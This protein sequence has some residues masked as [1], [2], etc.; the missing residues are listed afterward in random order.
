MSFSSKLH[1][2]FCYRYFRITTLFNAI[3]KIKK[4][5]E[6]KTIRLVR[7]AFIDITARASTLFLLRNLTTPIPI[8]D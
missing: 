4:L 2:K 6:K 5:L 8:I 1:L 7:H 3:D